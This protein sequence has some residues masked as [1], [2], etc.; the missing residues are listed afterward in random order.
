MSAPTNGESEKSSE[1]S[2]E[3]KA[4]HCLSKATSDLNCRPEINCWI[5]LTVPSELRRRKAPRESRNTAIGSPEGRGK[6]AADRILGAPAMG[7][8][9]RSSPGRVFTEPGMNHT[10]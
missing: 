10:S 3:K 6:S 2:F 1:I 4:Y 9:R 8:S 7:V 5:R